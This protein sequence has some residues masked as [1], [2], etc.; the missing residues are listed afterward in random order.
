MY[1]YPDFLVL[2]GLRVHQILL[3]V[4]AQLLHLLFNLTIYH[5]LCL[6]DFVIRS[7]V[8]ALI[9]GLK[10]INAQLHSINLGFGDFIDA[11]AAGTS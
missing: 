9:V 4:P 2:L 8:K 11:A 3:E 5:F 1:E 10:I 6:L 7:R